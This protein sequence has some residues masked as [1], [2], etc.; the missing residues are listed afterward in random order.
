M[1]RKLQNFY[2]NLL[3]TRNAYGIGLLMISFKKIIEIMENTHATFFPA[4]CII[5]WINPQPGGRSILIQWR[6]TVFALLIGML[7]LVVCCVGCQVGCLAHL[8]LALQRMLRYIALRCVALRLRLGCRV[9]SA[10]A[11]RTQQ[12][13]PRFQP[14]VYFHLAWKTNQLLGNISK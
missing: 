13:A 14:L 1:L 6:D 9:H 12:R 2:S 4:Y 10:V 11:C 8:S 7:V 5:C 3:A